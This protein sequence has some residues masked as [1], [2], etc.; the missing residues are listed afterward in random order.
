MI[1]GINCIRSVIKIGIR[2][3]IRIGIKIGIRIG[4]NVIICQFVKL[5]D[6]THKTPLGLINF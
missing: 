4:I 5:N 3:S 2:I 1:I 6:F